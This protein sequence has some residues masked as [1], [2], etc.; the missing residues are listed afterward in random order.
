MQM[1]EGEIGGAERSVHTMYMAYTQSC[2]KHMTQRLRRTRHLEMGA[3]WGHRGTRRSQYINR[4]PWFNQLLEG[5]G[6]F[7]DLG[8][9]WIRQH[10]RANLKCNHHWKKWEFFPLRLIQRKRHSWVSVKILKMPS[11][12]PTFFFSS[13][14]RLGRVW[15]LR[16]SVNLGENSDGNICQHADRLS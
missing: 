3:E 15:L 8:S 5:G 2:A 12:W 16:R 14:Y 10:A 13:Y 11:N 9:M 6:G 4:R 1:W 7:R